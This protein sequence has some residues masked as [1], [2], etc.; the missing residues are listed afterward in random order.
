[1]RRRILVQKY[2]SGVYKAWFEG[3]EAACATGNTPFDA[4]GVLVSNYPDASGI[5]VVQAL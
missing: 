1:M 4:V 5:E 3:I 2:P